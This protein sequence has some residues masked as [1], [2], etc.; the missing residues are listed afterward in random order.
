[1][2]TRRDERNLSHQWSPQWRPWSERIL[3][4]QKSCREEEENP[5]A[6]TMAKSNFLRT[7]SAIMCTEAQRTREESTRTGCPG[8][9]QQRGQD[10][11]GQIWSMHQKTAFLA[12][13]IL[14][15]YWFG[16]DLLA[17]Q[18]LFDRYSLPL[19]CSRDALMASKA[20]ITQTDIS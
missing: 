13:R 20:P 12:K 19:T 4:Y 14:H 3:W 15:D 2:K 6:Q 8:N 16:H 9:N 11:W 17:I 7:I 5:G 1:M 10:V 18:R